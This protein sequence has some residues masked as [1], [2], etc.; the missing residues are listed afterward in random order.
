MK[1]FLNELVIKGNASDFVECCRD[2]IIGA[3]FLIEFLP[4]L[5]FLLSEQVF[6]GWV[7][8]LVMSR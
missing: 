4:L 2:E 5:E 6:L 7:V 8:R 3:I 1:T